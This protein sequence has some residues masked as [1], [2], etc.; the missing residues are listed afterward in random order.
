MTRQSLQQK[1]Q[2]ILKESKESTSTEMK[3]SLIYFKQIL[4]DY[5][6]GDESTQNLYY[7]DILSGQLD[8]RFLHVVSNQIEY[9]LEN[10]KDY[11]NEI[12]SLYINANNISPENYDLRVSELI[13]SSWRDILDK[14]PSKSVNNQYFKPY[15]QIEDQNLIVLTKKASK[16]YIDQR[17]TSEMIILSK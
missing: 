16:K 14:L 8:A 6:F 3:Q 13:Q 12:K 17:P 7:F 2:E 15:C 9:H 4:Q 5:V 10:A 11:I 1:A